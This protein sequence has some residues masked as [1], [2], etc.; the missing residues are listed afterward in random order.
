MKMSLSVKSL[1]SERNYQ[2]IEA[3]LELGTSVIGFGM[4][5]T[6]IYRKLMM[7]SNATYQFS[8]TNLLGSSSF[9]M[10]KIGGDLRRLPMSVKDDATFDYALSNMV[11]NDT[12]TIRLDQQMRN[13]TNRFCRNGS[14]SL[15][16]GNNNCTL[17]VGV[18]CSDIC[19]YNLS[20]LMTGNRSMLNV[21]EPILIKE[22]Q[23]IT[24]NVTKLKPVYFF[25]P[26]A[27]PGN[28][29]N[30]SIIAVNKM[31]NDLLVVARF[32]NN[33]HLPY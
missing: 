10:V 30:E 24:K 15:M 33:T 1:E 22:G 16:G 20:V 23:S 13:S 11:F 21:S 9:L 5:E 29:G 19:A 17:Y 25:I 7:D 27:R 12:V 4:A 14:Y 2:K 31:S 26:F 18:Q 3:D 8:M 6:I 28:M 32:L